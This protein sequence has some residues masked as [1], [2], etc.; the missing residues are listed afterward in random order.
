MEQ[1]EITDKSGVLNKNGEILKKG[2]SFQCPYF[3][4]REKAAKSKFKI[5]EWDFYQLSNDKAVVQ[6]TIGHVSYAGAVNL[7]LFTLDGKKRYDLA[8]PLIFPMGKLKLPAN[9]KTIGTVKYEKKN[10][11]MIFETAENKKALTVKAKSKKYGEID[12][13]FDLDFDTGRDGIMVATP[14]EKPCEF[15]F[16]YKINCMRASGR[17]KFG[18]EEYLFDPQNTFCVL[19]W[20]RGVLPFSHTWWWGNGSA[21]IDGRLFGFNI[22]VFGD[23]RAA[24]ENALFYDGKGHKLGNIAL[25]KSE[26]G[27]M[28]DWVFTEENKRFEMT[29]T[30]IFDNHT[31]IKLLRVNNN[32]HQV[33][34]KWNGT[35]TLDGGETLQV[36]N[37]IAFCEVAHNNW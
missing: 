22:G 15:Y 6:L 18:S 11:S 1:T 23:N 19:D 13:R 36:K 25:K 3:F 5:K 26:D 21:D 29:M 10:Y 33:F 35:V 4:N 12:V 17:A 28:G 27:Y 2:Y 16:N 9:P 14:F 31:A 7:T 24:T 37:M 34:G 32:C 30:P 20:G 8:A